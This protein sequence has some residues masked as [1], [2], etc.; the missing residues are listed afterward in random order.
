M[1]YFGQSVKTILY[2]GFH[3][4]SG[5]IKKINI[6]N[7]DRFEAHDYY[8]MDDL[9][10]DEHKLI[11]DSTRAWVKKEIP[12]HFLNSELASLSCSCY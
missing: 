4:C 10:T 6:M 12:I 3:W 2:N 1:S 7:T 9:L 5:K 11:R 8:L